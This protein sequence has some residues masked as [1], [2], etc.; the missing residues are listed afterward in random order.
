MAG[1][2]RGAGHHRIQQQG[3][4]RRG[5]GQR[6]GHDQPGRITGAFA[7]R[8]QP[9]AGLQA[10]E[11]A[12]GGRDADRTA[13]VGPGGKGNQSGGHRRGAAAGGSPRAAAERVRVPRRRRDPVLA[14][15]R[16][17]ELR[18]LGFAQRDHAC[19]LERRD[20]GA[21]GQ[22]R[23]VVQGGAAVGRDNSG[24]VRQV[25]EGHRHAVQQR[26]TG[27]VPRGPGMGLVR[28]G[29]V[30]QGL[31][32]GDGDERAEVPVFSGDAVQEMPRG[33]PRGQLAGAEGIAEVHG[34]ELVDL[35]HGGTAPAGF[36][37]AAP[38]DM[39]SAGAG[40]WTW[41][42]CAQSRGRGRACPVEGA[43][44][45][46]TCPVLVRRVDMVALCPV[47]GGGGHVPEG[48]GRAARTVRR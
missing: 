30:Q 4:V 10:H 34:G 7:R 43:A 42:H 32:R 22:R 31:L 36:P 15:R 25:L 45:R 40:G 8:D 3:C 33:L 26:Q 29:G 19:A 9:A 18:D 37:P 23:L 48:R 2:V 6:P 35:S 16:Q 39:S 41:W 12:G 5:A 44:L 1:G 14:V 47:C 28:G 38:G 46:G 27:P 11:P 13:A 24:D 17:P 21:V 20:E